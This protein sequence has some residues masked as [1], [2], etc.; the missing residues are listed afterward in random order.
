MNVAWWL[1]HAA[2]ESPQR[3]ALVDGR[4]GEQLTYAELQAR[5]QALAAA[6]RREGG[7]RPGDVVA[8]LMGDDCW[9]T[10]LFYGVLRLGATF[11]GFNR[12][13]HLEKFAMDAE[14]SRVRVLV[15]GSDHV[16]VGRELLVRTGVERLL[17]CGPK[18]PDD[19]PD[20]RALSAAAAG[21]RVAM[22]LRTAEDIAAVNFTGGT[23]GVAKGVIFPHGR[24]GVSA[25]ASLF[26]DR[27]TSRDVNLTVISLC[28]S[29]GI[30][31]ALKWV[32]ARGTVILSGGWDAELCARLIREHGVTW[33]YFWVPTMIRDLM[34]R[35]D[36][37]D[38]PLQGVNAILCGEPVGA[39]L[40]RALL[41]RGM[42]VSNS[43]GMTESMPVGIL[44]PLAA[45]GEPAPAGSCGRPIIELCELVLKDPA[46]GH[47]IEQPGVQG[48]I[49][50]RGGVIT[51]G[52]H[53]DPERT[54]EA[55]DEEGFLHTR[56]LAHVDEDGWYWVG[57]RTDD[58]INSGAEKLS[59]VEVEEMLRRHPAVVD[60]ACIGVAHERFGE[61]PAA[62]VVGD[63]S[64]EE[65]DHHCQVNLERWK[66]PRLYMLIP[67][68]PRT[69]PKR[70]KDLARLRAMLEGVVLPDEP[71]VRTQC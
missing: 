25:Q 16:D 62:F 21:E 58:I 66:R 33:I 17:V 14:R 52:Y 39:E 29:G 57:G 5:A 26:Y 63:V 47:R 1:E 45:H 19:L 65:L 3:L 15:V 2:D 37:D 70:T 13:L 46:S 55:F 10:A 35:A 61:V 7:V 51:P 71:G 42:K 34:R 27:L 32:M 11:S 30:H 54:A 38:L 6:L 53:N 12:A 50:V 4:G 67:E 69:L 9:H 44:K 56:D 48:E 20:L 60:V 8:T 23:S 68:I 18:V 31:D 41:A 49:C 40:E 59:L 24:L 36:Y 43:Y 64:A 22:T 28:H